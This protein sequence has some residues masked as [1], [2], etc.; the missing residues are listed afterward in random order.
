MSL[1]QRFKKYTELRIICAVLSLTLREE[2]SLRVFENRAL[3]KWW[4]IKKAS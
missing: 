2:H 4:D 1:K 3:R